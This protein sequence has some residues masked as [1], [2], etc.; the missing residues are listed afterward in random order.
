MLT[1]ITSRQPDNA[2]GDGNTV[3]DIQG[4][5][6]GTADLSFL[7]RAERSP[8]GAPRTYSVVYTVSDGSGNSAQAV[9]VV[10]VPQDQSGHD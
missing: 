7:L 8:H 6:Y 2:L 5:A 10:I 9:G 4:A 1:S 3:N